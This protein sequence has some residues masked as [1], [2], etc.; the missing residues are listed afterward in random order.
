METP[1]EIHLSTM[2]KQFNVFTPYVERSQIVTGDY[3]HCDNVDGCRNAAE[4][5]VEILKNAM[6]EQFDVFMLKGI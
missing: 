3:V 5:S 4:I 2:V 1:V 6:I